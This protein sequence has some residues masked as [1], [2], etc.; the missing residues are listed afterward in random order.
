MMRNFLALIITTTVLASAAFAADS[1][2]WGGMI[3]P[4]ILEYGK[5]HSRSLG[6]LFTTLQSEYF[7]MFFLAVLLFVP[8]A[9]AGHY[10]IWGPKV[11]SHDGK[12]IYIFSVFNRLVHLLAA[13]SFLILVPTGF[14]M[15]F[16]K[17]L[18]GGSLVLMARQLHG[19]TTVIFLLSVIPMFLFWVAEMLPSLDDI[20]WLLI[21]GG[22]LSKKKREIP[23]GKFNAGQKMWFWLATLGGLVMILTGTAMFLQDFDLHIAAGLGLSQIDL[24][25]AAAIIHNLLAVAI[26]ALFFTHVYMS[27]FAIKGAIHSM[28]TGYK[29]EEEVQFLHS[30]YYRQL[31]N[32][33]KA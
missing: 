21:L 33:Q 16:G 24:L 2:I 20:K 17:Y 22:Y 27:L 3:I 5:I 15:A 28:I 31:K 6:P 10:F 8:V 11:F 25:R 29:E 14:M 30:S 18:G 9:F 19:M 1:Q 26:V 4:N 32:Q 12:K 7:R 23:A 13:L